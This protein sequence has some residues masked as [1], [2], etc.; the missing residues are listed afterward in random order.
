[1][2]TLTDEG[3]LIPLHPHIS[4]SISNG[5]IVKW[6]SV[7]DKPSVTKLTGTDFWQLLDHVFM[8]KAWFNTVLVLRS[9]ALVLT[10][11]EALNQKAAHGRFHFN[12]DSRNE[13]LGLNV[14]LL[15]G[16]LETQPSINERFVT[17]TTVYIAVVCCPSALWLRKTPTDNRAAHRLMTKEGNPRR[18]RYGNRSLPNRLCWNW[19]THN[20]YPLPP[21][22][23]DISGIG[24][25]Q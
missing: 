10:S 19:A 18:S 7:N 12:P 21:L 13:T 6:D 22:P 16:V 3:S 8:C 1:M 15:N 4:F 11:A 2:P 20:Q 14:K 5:S 24:S 17:T 23:Y 25:L 9:P